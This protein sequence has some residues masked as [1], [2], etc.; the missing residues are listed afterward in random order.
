M[1]SGI[2]KIY[3]AV[4]WHEYLC[5]NDQGINKKIFLGQE[6]HEKATRR[7]AEDEYEK[8]TQEVNRAAILI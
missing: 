1:Y 7:K 8:L 3:Y 5:S 6:G 4:Y 2:D